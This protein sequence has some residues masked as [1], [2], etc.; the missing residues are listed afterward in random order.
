MFISLINANLLALFIS[1]SLANEIAA[2]ASNPI[3]NAKHL[4]YSG[5][6]GYC[7]QFAIG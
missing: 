6:S 3:I 2:T 7:N 1:L 5:V 4:I